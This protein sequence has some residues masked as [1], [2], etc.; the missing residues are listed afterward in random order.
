MDTV[1]AAG[2]EGTAVDEHTKEAGGREGVEKKKIKRKK[3]YNYALL[4][5][6]C[7]HLHGYCVC[8]QGSPHQP[9]S[10]QI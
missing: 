10:L 6:C 3:K 4:I 7:F 5:Y 2:L 9:H 8:V 1:A